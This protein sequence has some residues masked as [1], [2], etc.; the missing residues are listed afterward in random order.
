MN[1]TRTAP[2]P[3]TESTRPTSSQ[4]TSAPSKPQ[5]PTITAK[6]TTSSD[7]RV[8]TAASTPVMIKLEDTL[9]HRRMRRQ[10]PSLSSQS[11]AYPQQAPS[12]SH[13]SPSHHG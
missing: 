4:S 10:H 7:H 1:R 11:P 3:S 8:L 6:K 9:E 5:A 2:D 12:H 13:L